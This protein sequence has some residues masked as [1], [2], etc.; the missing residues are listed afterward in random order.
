VLWLPREDQLR[1]RI[2]DRLVRLERRPDGWQVVT[3]YGTGE[4]AA[5]AGD[6]EDAYATALLALLA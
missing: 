3:S 4:R 6:V 1:E 5:A 2:G